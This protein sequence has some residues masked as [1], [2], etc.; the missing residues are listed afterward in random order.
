MKKTS[1][2]TESGA[3]F[4]A[5]SQELAATCIERATR[6]TRQQGTAERNPLRRELISRAL[7]AALL[8]SEW[9]MR[10]RYL[11]AA[12][13][14]VVARSSDATQLYCFFFSYSRNTHII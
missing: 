9:D 1:P 13:D 10:G 4:T 7:A 12:D 6:A 3:S 5:A 2:D 8:C 14:K 11:D